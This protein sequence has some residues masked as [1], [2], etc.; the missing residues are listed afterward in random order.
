[1]AKGKQLCLSFLGQLLTYW[2]KIQIQYIRNNNEDFYYF[3]L[4]DYQI[5]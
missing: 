1:M 4:Y 5:L 2:Y 3:Y